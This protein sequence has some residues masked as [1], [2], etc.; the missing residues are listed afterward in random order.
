MQQV[1][2][3]KYIHDH[4]DFLRSPENIFNADPRNSSVEI[5]GAGGF[6]EKTLQDHHGAISEIT[7]QGEVP[8]EIVVN[9]E[10]GKNL[11]LYSWF[12]YRFHAAARSHA[13]ECLELALKIRFRDEL[14]A[15]K[16]QRRRKQHECEIARSPDK[17][18]PYQSMDKKKFRP[19]LPALLKHAIEIG[20]LKNENFSAWRIKTQTRARTRR[21]I[22]AIEKMK[23]LGLSELEIDDGHLELNEEDCNHEYVG[24]L[25]E[26]IPLARNEYAHGTTSLDNQSLAG[27]RLTAEIINQI[28]TA[29]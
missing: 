7:L 16:E 13:Y 4:P 2:T 29:E 19:T 3:D 27:L 28:F 10:T 17:A 5:L 1:T 9:F 6:R 23:E 12:V 15:H 14:Y 24:P 18:R 21:S 20:A 8:Q 26:S 11:N 25:L 22:E